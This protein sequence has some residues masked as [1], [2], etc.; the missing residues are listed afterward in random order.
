VKSIGSRFSL[1]VGIFAIAFSAIVLYRT[2]SST[3]RHAEKLT[4]AQARL[5]L[6]FDLAIR[7][8]AAESIRP[9]MEKRV[10]PGEFVVEAMSTSY[11]ARR[12]V[13]KVREE[14]PDYLLKFSSDH[15]RN[16]INK[17]GPEEE[18]LIQYFRENPEKSRWQ[19]WLEIDGQKYFA[20][21]SAMRIEE[22][23]LRCHG[24]PQ[25]S[26]QS[27]L[28]RYG[29]EGG[30]HRELGDVAGMDLI[31]IPMKQTSL[32]IAQDA[33][34]NL[35]TTGL[36]LAV[37][38]GVIL[39]SFRHIVSRRLSTIARHF[40]TAAEAPE[41]AALTPVKVQGQDEI[42][43][44]ARSFNALAARLRTLQ[45]SL[46]QRVQQRTAELARANVELAKAK[47]EADLANR[48]KSDFLANMSHEIRTPMNAIIGMSDLV[49]DTK[50]TPTQREYLQTVQV[51]GESLMSLIEDIL[52]FSKI[53][54]NKLELEHT[55][56]SLHD[57]VGDLMRIL[58]DR[59]H[60]KGLELVCRIDPDVPEFLMGDPGRLGQIIVN[61]VGNAIK[62][63]EAGE[64]VLDVRCERR[65]DEESV[66]RFAV[67]D[68]GIGIEADKLDSIFD[69]FTQ[70]DA[71]TT[72]K[73]GGTGLGLA[74]ASRLS[75]R[76]GGRMWVESTAGSGSTF[77]FEA[78]FP[79]ARER[80]PKLVTA[81]VASLRGTRLLIVDDNATNRRILK[82]MAHDWGMD[83]VVASS[84]R[85]ALE[86]LRQTGQQDRP[87]DLLVSDVNMPEMDGITLA[88]QVR[89]EPGMPTIPIILLTSGARPGDLE[90]AA[91]LNIARYLVKP[92]EQSRLFDAIAK[93][94]GPGASPGETDQAGRKLTGKLPPLRI[95]LVEDSLVNQKLAAALLEKQ[96][97]TVQVATNG[98]EAVT[99]C[100]TG[101][102]DVVL[103]DVEMPIMD[104]LEATEHIREWEKGAQ[105]HLPIVAMTAHARKGD[106]ERCLEAGMDD[107]ISKPIRAQQLLDTLEAVL[108]TSRPTA[109][110]TDDTRDTP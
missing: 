97:H 74:I 59:A 76:M 40:R 5:A 2:W 80:P 24:E 55:A 29:T 46:E 72:R 90:R 13:E 62:F 8:Y 33:T 17:A 35:L 25:D 47:E 100:Q 95:L 91:A 65:T 75:A 18:E 27:L 109:E 85:D 9:E 36:W 93:C 54:A 45:E 14:F 32:A 34:V 82:E 61:L 44:L 37:L 31:A 96:G 28:T 66:L 23:C 63:T 81:K 43:V 4:A 52:D 49:L 19:G 16:P 51:A 56:F 7:E 64:V 21:V 98:S 6:E 104:G 106:R 102:F 11:I 41:D 71:S 15:P 20:H 12:V 77:Y 73:Y 3:Q 92:V 26:P 10:A 108:A 53:E 48:A 42:A 87:C 50:L 94:L 89:K 38:F 70:T 22:S 1:V 101:V 105:S 58:A 30:F 68:T 78:P 84:A 67:S 79:S 83:P 99:A 88:E 107:Y 86:I 69:A 39:T 103:M 110:S 57:S 60:G